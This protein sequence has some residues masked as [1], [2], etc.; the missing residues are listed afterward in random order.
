M[1]LERA[2]LS[3][4]ILT[5]STCV[6][7]RQR[8]EKEMYVSAGVIQARV[9]HIETVRDNGPLNYTKKSRQ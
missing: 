5:S 7:E 6:F 8:S 2:V 1:N 4:F 9:L 3:L